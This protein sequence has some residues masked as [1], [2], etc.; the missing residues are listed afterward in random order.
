MTRSEP[1]LRDGDH[2]MNDRLRRQRS[3]QMQVVLQDEPHLPGLR[4]LTSPDTPLTPS[5]SR[6]LNGIGANPPPGPKRQ[7]RSHGINDRQIPV[8]DA[9]LS[10]DQA[11]T[12]PTREL[13]EVV[14]G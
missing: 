7:T 2:A 11:V 8:A 13:A 6:K 1:A 10:F 3:P 12:T 14:A 4:C 9:H 5:Q